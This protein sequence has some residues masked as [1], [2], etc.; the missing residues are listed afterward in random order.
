MPH[1]PA[2]ERAP[3]KP[4]TSRVSRLAAVVAI[5]VVGGLAVGIASR[6]HRVDVAPSLPDP[7]GLT[8]LLLVLLAA[9]AGLL[10]GRNFVA[11]WA[12]EPDLVDPNRTKSRVPRILQVLLPILLLAVIAYVRIWANGQNGDR[13][14]PA[15]NGTTPVTVNTTPTSGGDLGLLAA[16]VLIGLVAALA[17]ARLFRTPTR[18]L[19]FP[20]TAEGPAAILDEGL[21]ALLAEA[22]PRRAVIAAYVAME[23]AM[24][25]QGW[26][27]RPAEAPSEYLAR[28]LGVAPAR[29]AD[30]DRLVGMYQL[31]RFSEHEVTPGM[32]AAAVATVRQLRADLEVAA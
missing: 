28:V 31:A 18:P 11:A 1:S 4:R 12:H 10:V 8:A 14:G 21:G 23:R 29:A 20:A 26:A 2:N 3:G 30:L 15:L 16:C 32:R 17:A 19:E 5:V 9:V 6:P 24:A 22:D 25:R 7:G 13:T 27:R